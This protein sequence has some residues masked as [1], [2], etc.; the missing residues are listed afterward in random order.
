V[1]LRGEVVGINTAL[2]GPG[3][4]NVGIGFATPANR[5]RSAMN[6]MLHP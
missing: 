3:G 6:R 5:V 4:G 1:N 2:I